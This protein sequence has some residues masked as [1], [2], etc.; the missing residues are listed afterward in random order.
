MRLV[1]VDMRIEL[2]GRPSDSE[3]AWTRLGDTDFLNR[4][5]GNG[6][7]RMRLEPRAEGAPTVLGEMDGLLGTKMS[8]IE[9]GSAWVHG[10]WFRQER[11]YVRAPLATSRF[12]LSLHP[13]ALGVVPKIRLE[14]EP[15]S[16]WLSPAIAAR[17]HSIRTRWQQLLDDLPGPGQ[18]ENAAL[19]RTLGPEALSALERWSAV[20]PP[21]VV[22]MVRRLFTTGRDLELQR[23]GAY[24]LAERFGLDPNDTLVGMLRGVRAGALELYWSVRCGRCGGTV[25]SVG[26]LSD[27]ADHAE[28]PSC[29]IAFAPDLAETVEVLFAPHPAIVPRVEEQFCTLFPGGAPSIRAAF[30]LE[31]GRS[32]EERVELTPGR[33]RLGP[34]GGAPDVELTVGREGDDAVAWSSGS[35]GE[36][37]VKA[38]PVRLA[39]NN[40]GRTHERVILASHGA[41]APVVPASVVAMLPE[42]RKEFGPAA[43]SPHVRIAARTV[44]LLFTDLSG[45][46]A[47]YEAIGDA[48]AYGIV[49]DHFRIL[50]GVVDAHRGL[51]V[52]TIGDAVMASFVTA[53]DALAAALAM[54]AAFDAWIPTQGVEPVPRLNVGMHVGSALAVHTTSAGLDWFG[55][56][57][58]LAARAQ[59]AARQGAIVFTEAFGDDP[60]VRARLDALGLV[61]VPFDAELKG[62]GRVVLRTL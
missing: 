32:L 1:W 54:R 17:T 50:E 23:M 19:T 31:P 55:R 35:A 9:H 7:I 6:A 37:R 42:F 39:V 60:Q 52:K 49:R 26:S 44:A 34:G 25:S 18:P 56:T 41:A 8:F 53:A 57:V 48:Q 10:R 47:M 27:I 21:D 15:S 30:S 36:R 20:G 61:P 29:R 28:C 45:S 51:L 62:F 5:A 24:A 14:L 22:D 58:N 38:G 16:R 43:L 33:W 11:S 59:G 13:H 2:E 40:D 4:V 3:V 46:T 12:E